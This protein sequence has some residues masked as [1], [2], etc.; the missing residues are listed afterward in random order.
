M[1]N[2]SIYSAIWSG[3]DKNQHVANQYTVGVCVFSAIHS[4]IVSLVLQ[5]TFSLRDASLRKFAGA[6]FTPPASMLLF[7][8]HSLKVHD[9][10]WPGSVFFSVRAIPIDIVF[11]QFSAEVV[12]TFD[13]RSFHRTLFDA[14]FYVTQNHFSW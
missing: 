13:L 7:Y 10:D 6:F 4:L 3:A 14:V 2:L 12:S 9:T 1:R 11:S 8:C 5:A